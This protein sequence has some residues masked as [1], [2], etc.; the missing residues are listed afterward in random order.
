MT[1]ERKTIFL[2]DYNVTNLT[3]GKN[4]LAGHYKVFTMS[5]G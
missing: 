5:S 4:A 3:L 1:E 2:V